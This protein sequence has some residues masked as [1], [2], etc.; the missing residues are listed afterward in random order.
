MCNDWLSCIS[1]PQAP[2]HSESREAER[3]GGMEQSSFFFCL[4]LTRPYFLCPFYLSSPNFLRLTF[5]FFPFSLCDS[6]LSKHLLQELLSLFQTPFPP[7]GTRWNP[8][9]YLDAHLMT[10]SSNTRGILILLECRFVKSVFQS[11]TTLPAVPGNYTL[12]TWQQQHSHWA[13]TASFKLELKW[14]PWSL[15]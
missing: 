9:I 7:A 15:L 2:H 3:G 12:V 10:I 8:W 4:S 5:F 13:T 14:K 11:E 6:L 1:R